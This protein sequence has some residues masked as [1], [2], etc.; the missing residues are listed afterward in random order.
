MAHFFNR[1]FNRN[2][3]DNQHLEQKN[4]SHEYIDKQYFTRWEWLEEILL[5]RYPRY[6]FNDNTSDRVTI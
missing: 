1:K 4:H 2:L 6:I 3:Q 5:T